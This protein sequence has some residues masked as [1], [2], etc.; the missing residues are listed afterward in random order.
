MEPDET[1]GPHIPQNKTTAASK[2]RRGGKHCPVCL[3]ALRKITPGTR[4]RKE[5][6]V[7]RAHPSLGKH[8]R[9]CPAAAIW[10]NKSGAACQACGH[11][12]TKSEVVSSTIAP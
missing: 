2:L 10:E 8:C 4:L 6:V 9:R 5:C 7:C 12:G 11:H 1:P 3:A